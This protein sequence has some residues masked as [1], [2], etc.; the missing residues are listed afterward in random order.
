MT[1]PPSIPPSS[2]PVPSKRRKGCLMGCGI[3]TLILLM[4]GVTV[5][6]TLWQF[7]R[8]LD[9][10]PIQA[11]VL[12][13]S[14]ELVFDQKVEQFKY[15]AGEMDSAPRQPIP[16]DRLIRISERELN[17]ALAKN[18]DLAD[19]MFLDLEADHI[20]LIAN[21]PMPADL[22]VLGGRTLRIGGTM[23]ITTEEGKPSVILK[24]VMVSGIS[25]PN[26]WTGY[27]KNVNLIEEISE[28]NEDF[29]TFI[30]GVHSLRVEPD[31]LLIELND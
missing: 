16:A 13:P 12:T 22:P 23:R 7:K 19:K 28:N 5:L 6:L 27:R 1:T 24:K 26:A 15:A 17:A 21:F 18:T 9:P 14:E 11:T 8:N 2:T 29:Q 10:E 3:V 30:A 4:V 31:V 25:I 20:E